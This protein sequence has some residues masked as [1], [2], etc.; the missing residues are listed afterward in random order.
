[1]VFHF[2]AVSPNTTSGAQAALM[3]TWQSCDCYLPPVNGPFLYL[4]FFSYAFAPLFCSLFFFSRLLSIIAFSSLF[5][6]LLIPFS[7][8]R[9]LFIGKAFLEPADYPRV[10]LYNN[11]TC[12]SVYRFRTFLIAAENFLQILYIRK[13]LLKKIGGRDKRLRAARAKRIADAI[14]PHRLLREGATARLYSAK[15]ARTLFVKRH[16]A[17]AV[18]RYTFSDFLLLHRQRFISTNYFVNLRL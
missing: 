13:Y 17:A 16:I 3:T 1:M 2:R 18:L 6:F 7:F 8:A 11:K 9:F 5:A 4:T 14:F 15:T 12:E 10:F